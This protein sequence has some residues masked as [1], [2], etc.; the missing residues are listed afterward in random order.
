MAM[1]THGSLLGPRLACQFHLTV[2]QL[3]TAHPTEGPGTGEAGGPGARPETPWTL[4]ETSQVTGEHTS[5]FYIL[6]VGS[7]LGSLC[8]DGL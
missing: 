4:T 2:E 6:S 5:I 3:Q 8:A 7:Q 1:G